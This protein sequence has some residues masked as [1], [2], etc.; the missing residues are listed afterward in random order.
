[1]KKG[2]KPKVTVGV[3]KLG[4]WRTSRLSEVLQHVIAGDDGGLSM[5]FQGPTFVAPFEKPGQETKS[6]RS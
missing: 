1:M 6:S 4:Q 3:Q 5:G 2:G